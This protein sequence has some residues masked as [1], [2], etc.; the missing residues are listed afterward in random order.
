VSDTDFLY[1]FIEADERDADGLLADL[2]RSAREKALESARLREETA[3][4]CADELTRTARAMAHA[5][6]RG[7]RLFTFGN[8]GSATDA[9]LAAER[10][11][12]TRTPLG[13]LPAVCLT[14][15][16]AVITAL[17]NDV[18]FDLVFARSLE[19]VGREGDLALGCSTSGG[20]HNV[21]RGFA[22]AH[23]RGMLTV[24]LAG[25]DGGAMAGSDDVDH[26]L[27]VRS[28]S[29]HRIQEAQAALLA[30]LASRVRAELER[31]A[32]P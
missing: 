21:L 12:R 16:P 15:A 5:F 4:A 13:E 6:W 28:Q 30:D 23:A 11:G 10:F 2:A 8:G 17:G 14:D 25:Y 19:A 18:G 24:G 27:I 26:C 29:V 20:S 1:P 22:V 9:R 31:E 7:G 3:A 32:R